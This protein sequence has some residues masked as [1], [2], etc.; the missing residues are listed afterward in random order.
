MLSTW[1]ET[2]FFFKPDPKFP[3]GLVQSYRCNETTSWPLNN[4]VPQS[5]TTESQ[6]IQFNTL[7]SALSS[8]VTFYK[9]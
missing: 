2:E 1:S 7:S 9:I 8:F 6:L 3:A 4:E 5:W